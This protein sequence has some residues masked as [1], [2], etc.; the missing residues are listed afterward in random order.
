MVMLV[1]PSRKLQ[2]NRSF[3]VPEL[4]PAPIGAQ[5]PNAGKPRQLGLR[6]LLCVLLAITLPGLAGCRR[7]PP[8]QALRHT[9]ATMQAAAEAHDTD[10]LF[11][12]I[13]DDFVGSEGMDRQAFRRYVTFAGMRN[14]QVNVQLGPLDVKLFDQRA[15]VS[16]TAALSGGASWLPEHAQVYQVETGWR[17]EGSKWKLISA[18]WKPSL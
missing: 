12:P 16:F 8:E 3:V 11:E 7:E 1:F 5:A 18:T 4:L 10:A 14:Q 6:G 17:M 15:T 13:A 9:I 2:R